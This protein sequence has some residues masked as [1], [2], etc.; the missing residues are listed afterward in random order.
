MPPSGVV[1]EAAQR[2]RDHAHPAS[3]A[4]IGRGRLRHHASMVCPDPSRGAPARGLVRLGAALPAMGV[5]RNRSSPGRCV[6]RRSGSTPRFSLRTTWMAPVRRAASS[7]ASSAA[8]AW[9]TISHWGDGPS[10]R[11]RRARVD[12]SRRPRSATGRPCRCCPRP[13][14]GT[15]D[16]PAGVGDPG[17]QR[18]HPPGPADV[19]RGRQGP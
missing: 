2:T 6:R 14:A 19:G 4:Q 8:S 13:R 9:K 1:N 18:R 11:R 12:G 16:G 17:E 15:R 10:S 3:A 7:A 5:R